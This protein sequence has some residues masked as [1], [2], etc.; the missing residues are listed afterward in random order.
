MAVGVA[1][2]GAEAQQEEDK[3]REPHAVRGGPDAPEGVDLAVRLRL[4]AVQRYRP[5]HA[6]QRRVALPMWSV[7]EAL[8][9]LQKK[10]L[11]K[12]ARVAEELV[13]VVVVRN[14]GRQ[15][16]VIALVELLLVLVLLVYVNVFVPLIEDHVVDWPNDPREEKATAVR[17][18]REGTD[19]G[20]GGRAVQTLG[21]RLVGRKEELCEEVDNLGHES[22]V[23]SL[24]PD[25]QVGPN[26][27]K[28]PRQ[29]FGGDLPGTTKAG[30]H[31]LPARTS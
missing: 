28:V 20:A 26:F 9:V 21:P 27:G 15:E 1:R 5:V 2:N 18:S 14:V 23:A 30:C 4:E 19:V 22:D 31:W 29:L 8:P 10:A 7:K 17:L 12:A 11:H 16:S 3:V 13:P 25:K 24:A 6:R